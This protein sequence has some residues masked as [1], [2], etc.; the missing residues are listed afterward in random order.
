MQC[1]QKDPNRRVSA[2]KLLKHPWILSAKRSEPVRLSA[3]PTQ[4]DEAV[5]KVQQWNEALKSPD[6]D[7]IRRPSRP[8]SLSP[9]PTKKDLLHPNP[10]S[11]PGLSKPLNALNNRPNAEAFRSPELDTDDNWDADFESNISPS[12]LQHLHLKPHDNFAGQLSPEKLKQYATFESVVDGSNYEESSVSRNQ[13]S[14]SQVD[15]LETLRPFTPQKHKADSN[16]SNPPNSSSIRQNNQLKTQILRDASG[17]RAPGPTRSRAA[18]R[19]RPSAVFREDTVE[20]YSDLL[21]GDADD[22]AFQRK[23]QALKIQEEPSFSPKLFHPS[24]LKSAPKP[25]SYARKSS[26]LRRYPTPEERKR[27][28]LARSRSSVEIQKYAEDENEDPEAFLGND[29]VLS[30]AE[31]DSGSERSMLMMRN[32]KLSAHSW[33]VDEEEEDDPFAQLEE[34]FDEMDLEANVARDRYARQCKEVEILVSDIQIGQPEEV[35]IDVTERLVSVL[36]M[37]IVQSLTR[38]RLAT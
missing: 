35:L 12:A 25:P 22:D 3:Q 21:A 23:V 8:N 26:S 14:A 9:M 24:D 38:T 30:L 37:L 17:N 13:L 15:P 28:P 19:A 18:P 27:E 31:S 5:K 2:D 34:D 16:R 1:F 20:D 32:S 4:Y 6:N 10:L 7:S 33:V 11:T 36:A 29:L